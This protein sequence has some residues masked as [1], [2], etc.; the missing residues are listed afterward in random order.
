MPFMIAGPG[1]EPASSTRALANSVDIFAT[2][3][4]LS[5]VQ[6]TEDTSKS[7]AMHSVSLKPVLLNDT[8]TQV[9]DFAYADVFG[10]VRNGFVDSRAI[11]NQEYKLVQNRLDNSEELY[12]LIDDPYEKNNLL[13]GKLSDADK[14]NYEQLL[15]MLAGLEN[16]N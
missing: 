14:E 8:D 13:V 5:G 3:L 7:T 1:I 4:E 16:K 2:V 9:R 6:L 15:R 11:R 10:A 12:Q